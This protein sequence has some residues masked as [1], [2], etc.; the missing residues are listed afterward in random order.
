VLR[1]PVP[2]GDETGPAVREP[3][4]GHRR[5]LSKRDDEKRRP[6]V[7]TKIPMPMPAEWPYL[8]AATCVRAVR[9]PK[10]PLP[11]LLQGWEHIVNVGLDYQL[12][13]RPTTCPTSLDMRIHEP[14]RGTRWKGSLS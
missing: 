11:R 8:C 6:D 7:H 14:G 1:T 10:H 5:A 9:Q 4:I 13:A 12:A 3:H 2:L